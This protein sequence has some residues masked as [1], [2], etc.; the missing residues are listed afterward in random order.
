M[1]V[2]DEG[3]QIVFKEKK[4]AE[5]AS[6]QKGVFVGPVQKPSGWSDAQNNRVHVLVQKGEN[7][8]K[9][10]LYGGGGP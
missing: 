7:S 10:Y 6:Y 5:N 9:K 1:P 2:Y 4:H 3:G 8:K